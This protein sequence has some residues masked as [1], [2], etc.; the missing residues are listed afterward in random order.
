MISALRGA[1]VPEL[2]VGKLVWA[3][4]FSLFQRFLADCAVPRA[5]EYPADL[6]TDQSHLKRLEEAIREQV[7]LFIPVHDALI[8]I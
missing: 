3:F 2:K 7:R 4:K 5:W 8:I 6:V 1:G